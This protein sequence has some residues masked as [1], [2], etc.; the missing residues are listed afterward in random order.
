MTSTPLTPLTTSSKPREALQTSVTLPRASVSNGAAATAADLLCPTRTRSSNRDGTVPH[1][2]AEASAPDSDSIG[3]DSEF[4]DDDDE[5]DDSEE[6]D[7]PRKRKPLRGVG[8]ERLVS[9]MQTIQADS[10]LLA[11]LGDLCSMS[12]IIRC[13]VVFGFLSYRTNIRV[14]LLTHVSRPLTNTYLLLFFFSAPGPSTTGAAPRVAPRRVK[15]Q[16]LRSKNKWVDRHLQAEDG[17]DAFIDLAD[18]IVEDDDDDD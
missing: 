10:L 3:S 7:V 4:E 2:A 9:N 1:A 5:E 18:W 12:T 17:D 8:S 16:R 13:V 14:V 15:R 6:D 11:A